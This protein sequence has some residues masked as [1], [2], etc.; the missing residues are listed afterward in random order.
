MYILRWSRLY[1]LVLR[2]HGER[3]EEGGTIP[4]HWPAFRLSRAGCGREGVD[5]FPDFYP[6]LSDLIKYLDGN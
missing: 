5:T 2:R 6:D 4:K 1:S 3:Y